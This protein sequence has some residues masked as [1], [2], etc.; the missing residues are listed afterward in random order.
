MIEADASNAQT[1]AFLKERAINALD[2]V[3]LIIEKRV[4][5]FGVSQPT[6]QKQIGT[7]RIFVELPGVSDKATVRKKLQATAS[8]EFYEIYENQSFGISGILAKSEEALSQALF[9]GP[10]DLTVEPEDTLTDTTNVDLA[11]STAVEDDLLGAA[12][13][14]DLLGDDKTKKADSLLTDQEREE[15]YPIRS[16]MN[17]SFEYDENNQI[18]GYGQ[19][20]VVGYASIADTSAL[21]YRLKHPA[22]RANLPQDLV[23]MWDAKEILDEDRLPTGVIYLHAIKVPSSGAKV[24]GKDIKYAALD[25]KVIGQYAVSMV[26]NELGSQKWKE[27]TTENLNKQVAITM[28]NY[29]FSAP[30]VNDIME[31]S[32]SITGN[33]TMAEQKI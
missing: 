18:V 25:D 9:G 32:S 22:I 14:D 20:S 5:Q 26:M 21:N 33:F 8:L 28:D 15:R 7:N 2:G 29:V 17:L 11:D 16:L 30:V 4:N 27:M 3:E 24:G 1:A 19:G 6:I 23:F 31:Q 12:T 10:I 13:N